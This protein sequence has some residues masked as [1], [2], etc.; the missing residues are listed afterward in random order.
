MNTP[1]LLGDARTLLPDGFVADI[2]ITDPPY[3]AHV[4]KNTTSQDQH[5]G[6]G[7]RHND[8]GF[9]CMTPELMVWLC[10]L[11]ARTRRWSIIYTD[12]E[13]VALWKQ[14]LELAG[15]TYIRT[16]PWV[17]WSIPQLSGDRPPQ[18][19]ECLVVA[20]GSAKGKKHWNGA[21]N[22][23]HLAHQLDWN[24]PDELLSH[25]VESDNLT[26]LAHLAMRGAEKHKT[27]KPLDQLLD[28]VSWFSDRGVLD[29]GELVCDP[30]SGSGTTGLAC[31]ILGRRFI[32]CELDVEWAQKGNARIRACKVDDLPGSLSP[33]DSERFLRWVTTSEKEKVDLVE[34]KFNTDRVR[35]R[36]ADK[37]L[38]LVPA[39]DV[40]QPRAI[41]VDA[42]VDSFFETEERQAI[43]AEDPMIPNMWTQAYQE[44]LTE[45]CA[46]DA[47]RMQEWR[48]VQAAE[49]AGRKTSA[50]ARTVPMFPA[51]D[52]YVARAWRDAYERAVA[53]LAPPL[54]PALLAKIAEKRA[55]D[56]GAS[57]VQINAAVAAMPNGAGAATQ[58]S[59]DP[60]FV[61]PP[62]ND[63][64]SGFTQPNGELLPNWANPKIPDPVTGPP[65]FIGERVA[66]GQAMPDPRSVQK[67]AD[68]ERAAAATPPP[69]PVEKRG[70]G[71]PPGVK[72][73][74]PKPWK[75]AYTR[76]MAELGPA[77]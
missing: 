51:S 3:R 18:G 12:I 19:F 61:E 69:A 26:H 53:E 54:S 23:T 9:G 16:L 17:R 70:K 15:A 52:E 74:A 32:G 10:Q 27:Q 20:H 73:K 72:N 50:A 34:R 8:L 36:M 62:K 68:A 28:L 60:D 38:A 31:K 49:A 44:C 47:G 56:D 6:G 13:S 58:V 33:R 66:P 48:D 43:E 39:S 75:A 55:R 29:Q 37:K 30:C 46:I 1:V 22:L 4:H 14:E 77:S 7:I 2:L 64:E 42:D 63:S 25:L 65:L 41:Q 57:S 21:G 11:A 59:T 76:V 35:K 67:A 24:S 40:E 71:R 45:V 5:N